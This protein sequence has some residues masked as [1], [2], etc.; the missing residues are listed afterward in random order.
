MTALYALVHL[1][2][3]N[4]SESRCLCTYKAFLD[5]ITLCKWAVQEAH[6]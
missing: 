3:G 5:A 1:I 4:S 2:I 6:V